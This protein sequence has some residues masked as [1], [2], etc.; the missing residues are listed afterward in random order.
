MEINSKNKKIGAYIGAAIAFILFQIISR[1]IFEASSVKGID[2]N[3]LIFMALTSVV[4]AGL[5]SFFVSL[6]GRKPRA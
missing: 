1:T 6:I 5:G 3:R 2:D 4:G